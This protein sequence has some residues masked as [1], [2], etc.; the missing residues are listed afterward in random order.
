[1]RERGRERGSSFMSFLRFLPC[2]IDAF[3]GFQ[4]S[5]PLYNTYL[6]EIKNKKLRTSHDVGRLLLVE[7]HG[8][9]SA[10]QG[11]REEENLDSYSC[12]RK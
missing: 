9:S 12:E 1:M 10:L 5:K 2:G 3:H 8:T 7:R 11:L 6:L 4:A